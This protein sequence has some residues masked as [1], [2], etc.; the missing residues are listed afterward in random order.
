MRM[1]HK[2]YVCMCLC[3]GMYIWY[4][5][6]VYS[7][8]QHNSTRNCCYGPILAGLAIKAFNNGKNKPKS[9]HY[10]EN[11]NTQKNEFNKE[12]TSLQFMH[13][14]GG[15]KSIQKKNGVDLEKMSSREW[16]FEM[17]LSLRW[18]WVRNGRT[19]PSS[20]LFI[21]SKHFKKINGNKREN[22]QTILMKPNG[23]WVYLI[24]SH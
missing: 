17:G 19:G 3:I 21:L 22:I 7:F 20:R 10:I 1:N 18:D 2:R 15:L 12:T 4:S 23:N 6:A 24:I 9:K 13:N 11:T 14:R 8:V 5:Y 16:K